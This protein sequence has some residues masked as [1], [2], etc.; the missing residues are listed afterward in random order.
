[1]ADD[2]REEHGPIAQ[3][4]V[5]VDVGAE[6]PALLQR[7]ELGPAEIY[8]LDRSCV[9]LGR[10]GETGDRPPVQQLGVGR[11]LD[12]PAD[13]YLGVTQ[14]YVFER[15]PIDLVGLRVGSDAVE[16]HPRAARE[17]SVVQRVL[18]R[19]VDVQRRRPDAH[20]A[21]DLADRQADDT[22]LGH[23]LGRGVENLLDRLLPSPLPAV[24]GDGLGAHAV[25]IT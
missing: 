11:V 9:G 18:R 13:E 7:R 17:Q 22:L 15:P 20:A 21:G 6:K 10:R 24:E 16:H 19:E 2:A 14:Q 3:H 8:E 25:S 12:R 1:L 4:V 23:D 5:D